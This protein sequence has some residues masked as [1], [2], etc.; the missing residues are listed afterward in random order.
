[1]SN[2]P[3]YTP[4][5]AQQ[6]GHI[7]S[8]YD[9]HA[10]IYDLTRWL[11]LFGRNKLIGQLGFLK[12]H[13]QPRV[14]EIGCGTGYML[15]RI[16]TT[17][18]NT[19]VTGIDTA[20]AMLRKAARNL[21]PFGQRYQLFAQPY[22]LRH[23]I[24]I[25]LTDLAICSYSLTMM[26]PYYTDIIKQLDADLKHNGHIA[27][28][29]FHYSKYPWFRRWMGMN[30]VV[31]DKQIVPLLELYFDTESLEI[32]QGYAGLWEYFVYVGKKRTCTTN[33]C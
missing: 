17:Y 31:M 26:Y 4:A 12:N 20:S 21:M 8:Y 28:V 15:R 32:R 6:I 14:L 2:S 33:L 27:V 3:Q 11:F 9:K 7:Q 10:P 1:M 5:V 18:T 25:G 22:T 30:H 19:S 16:L 24:A 23:H 29:D 13:L